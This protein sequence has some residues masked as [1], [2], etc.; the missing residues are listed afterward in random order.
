MSG[1]NVSAFSSG[2]AQI[3]YHLDDGSFLKIDRW[4]GEA[5]VEV[6]AYEVACA[7][8]FSNF[9]EY[10]LS[11]VADNACLSPNFESMGYTFVP[12]TTLV[13]KA[14]GC[15]FSDWVSSHI[16]GKPAGHRLRSIFKVYRRFGFPPNKVMGYLI[17]MFQIDILLRNTDRHFKNFGLFEKN[18]SYVF[19]RVFDNGNG[20]G[21]LEKWNT[22]KFS[23]RKL[24]SGNTDLVKMQPL[25]KSIKLLEELIGVPRSF[26]VGQFISGHDSRIGVSNPH[27]RLLLQV[28]VRYYPTYLGVSTE[29]LFLSNFGEFMK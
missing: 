23:N 14:Y 11:P 3:K 20:L 22:K 19:G 28:L 18:G 25:S 13:R 15:S 2:G 5:V 6:L 27:F 9:L 21:V 8:G 4:G 16:T 26:D 17:P 29:E 7:C 12:F 1:L 10:K 24:V